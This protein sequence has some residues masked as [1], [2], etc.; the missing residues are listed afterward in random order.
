MLK[1]I[2]TPKAIWV[3]PN[4]TIVDAG[5]LKSFDYV[6]ISPGTTI[7]NKLSNNEF[8]FLD[9]EGIYEGYMVVGSK[10]LKKILKKLLVE[11]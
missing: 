10:E 1:E 4:E 3:G 8:E 11:Y 9:Q 7:I 2:K 6:G 5:L